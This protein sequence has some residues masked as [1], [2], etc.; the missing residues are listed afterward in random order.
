MVTAMTIIMYIKCLKWMHC[1]IKLKAPLKG[2]TEQTD[3]HQLTP[4][5]K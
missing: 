5:G 4:R 2:R 3:Y 1:V